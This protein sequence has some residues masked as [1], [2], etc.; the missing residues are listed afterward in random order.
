MH[1]SSNQFELSDLF[2]FYKFHSEVHL[3]IDINKS[4]TKNHNLTLKEGNRMV[5]YIFG[6]QKP[7]QHLQVSNP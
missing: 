4:I 6:H 5:I 2:M 7:P 3:Y 1:L